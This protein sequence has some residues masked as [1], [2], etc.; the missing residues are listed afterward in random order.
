MTGAFPLAV[1]FQLKQNGTLW[2]A[3]RVGFCVL[4]FFFALH[5][6]TAVYG[7]GAPARL[8]PSTT[9][10][11]WP[12]EQKMEVQT[13]DAGAGALFCMAALCLVEPLVRREV[14]VHSA[15]VTPPPDVRSRRHLHRFLRPP[16]VQA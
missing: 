5:A 12:S 4:V 8:A 7:G 14:F 16:P 3:L 15:F 2:R 13:F 6:K 9:A 11:L 10:K 1:N